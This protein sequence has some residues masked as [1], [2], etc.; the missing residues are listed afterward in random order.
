M[1]R[2]TLQRYRSGQRNQRQ[3][4]RPRAPR[5]SQR[6]YNELRASEAP[7]DGSQCFARN[8]PARN[9]DSETKR[10]TVNADQPAA[11]RSARDT[12]HADVMTAAV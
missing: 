9:R 6:H 4:E 12:A 1:E 10:Q 2:S 8:N 5:S 3:Q 7:C 11:A